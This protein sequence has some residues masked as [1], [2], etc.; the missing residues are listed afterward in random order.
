MGGSSRAG[1][2]SPDRARVRPFV[3]ALVA[4]WLTTLGVAALVAVTPGA[5]EAARS[6]LAFELRPRPGSLEET[7]QIAVSNARVMSLIFVVAIVAR[8]L[9]S[10]RPT[11][12]AAAWTIALV[13]VVLV[14]AA[15]GAYPGAAVRWLPHVPFEWAGLAVALAAF[16]EESDAPRLRVEVRR[17]AIATALLVLGA[18]V[19]VYL[20]PQ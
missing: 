4:L 1:S 8:S 7:L 11:G 16:R 19:E 15:I 10:T 14:A 6:A 5:G 3:G 2:L 13:N 20:T 12:V 9:P 17:A 18:G